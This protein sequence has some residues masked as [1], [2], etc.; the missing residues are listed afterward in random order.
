MLMA[1]RIAC[2]ARELKPETGDMFWGT[3]ARS[4][5]RFSAY[6]HDMQSVSAVHKRAQDSLFSAGREEYA[7]AARGESKAARARAAA[8]AATI[9]TMRMAQCSRCFG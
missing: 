9:E 3:L 2:G 7:P 1:W 8:S 6:V 4:A 5:Q